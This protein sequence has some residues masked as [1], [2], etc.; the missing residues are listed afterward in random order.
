MKDAEKR[1][2]R[3]RVKAALTAKLEALKKDHMSKPAGLS[4]KEKLELIRC[5]EEQG[6]ARCWY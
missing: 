6:E 1:Y 3:E 5:N 4:A 2:C